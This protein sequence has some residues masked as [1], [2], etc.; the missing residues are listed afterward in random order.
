[1][2]QYNTKLTVEIYKNPINLDFSSLYPMIQTVDLSKLEAN[3]RSNTQIPGLWYE[4]DLIT[5]QEEQELLAACNSSPWSNTLKR[6]V[7]HYGYIYN[8]TSRKIDLKDKIGE[9][10]KWCDVV[11]KKLAERGMTEFDQLIVNQY[12]PGE[13]IAS[14]T[15]APSMFKDG[16]VS[17]SLGSDIIMNFAGPSG[18]NI[19]QHLKRRSAVILHGDARYK[20]KHEIKARKTD[21]I[22]GIRTNRGTRISLTFR[23]VES[24]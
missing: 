15:D 10:P 19:E 16:I 7:Q 2:N 13:G 21:T 4:Q 14:H 11:L 17:I 22:N 9:L 5:E 8:Y 18:E 12:L 1:M 24:K 6:K 23:R 3:A 20:W